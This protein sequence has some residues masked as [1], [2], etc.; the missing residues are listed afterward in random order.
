IGLWNCTIIN[1]NCR[2]EDPTTQVNYH[3]RHYG[4]T[5]KQT[6]VISVNIK[7]WATAHEYDKDDLADNWADKCCMRSAKSWVQKQKKNMGS[8][9]SSNS[10]AKVQGLHLAADVDQVFLGA[11]IAEIMAQIVPAPIPA[12]MVP[13]SLERSHHCRIKD[14]AI[15]TDIISFQL[16][17]GQWSKR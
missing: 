11:N 9:K 1:I 12:T 7:G 4:T 17:I 8:T 13:E 6:I 16:I 15:C 14:L 2:P 5:P 10:L 3:V